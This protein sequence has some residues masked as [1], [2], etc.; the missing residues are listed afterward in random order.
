MGRDR[1]KCL[2]G[3]GELA[4][5]EGEFADVARQVYAGEHHFRATQQLFGS[6]KEDLGLVQFTDIKVR[7]SEI[8]LQAEPLESVPT[9]QRNPARLFCDRLG[10]LQAGTALVMQHDKR[11]IQ[12][13]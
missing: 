2:A 13:P 9:Y 5:S 7:N 10:A 4:P 8:T 6:L 12:S 1:S 11:A 3:R